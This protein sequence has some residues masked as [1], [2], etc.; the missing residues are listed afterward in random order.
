MEF[1][2]ANALSLRL[3]LQFPHQFLARLHPQA[4]VVVA[5]DFIRRFRTQARH[6]R[7]NPKLSGTTHNVFG[8]QVGVSINLFVRKPKSKS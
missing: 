3:D 2:C 8:F 1:D 6:G 5:A 7:K 4:G